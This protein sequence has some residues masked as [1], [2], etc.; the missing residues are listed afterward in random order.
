MISIFS[1]RGDGVLY[2]RFGVTYVKNDT[3]AL[4]YAVI[5]YVA[6]WIVVLFINW[7]LVQAGLW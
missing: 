4:A 1:R 6:I 2:G 3:V 7:Q 5:T